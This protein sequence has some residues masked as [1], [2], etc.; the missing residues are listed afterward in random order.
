MHTKKVIL[1]LLLI[2]SY[3]CF[4]GN[5][6][7]QP[8]QDADEF[9]EIAKN[10]AQGASTMMG[11]SM[12]QTEIAKAFSKF[13]ARITV[14]AIN[15]ICESKSD[16]SVDK[17]QK[18]GASIGKQLGQEIIALPIMEDF[19]SKSEM[20]LIPTILE[21]LF[22]RSIQFL[23]AVAKIGKASGSEESPEPE[24]FFNQY[25]EYWS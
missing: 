6:S 4:G 15:T 7:P 1:S 8:N 24:D 13:G 23:E 25:S 16:N 19:L 5:Q 21:Y 9:E 14:H 20:H 17:Y 10:M 11:L 18:M 22:K 3:F 2:N 12:P